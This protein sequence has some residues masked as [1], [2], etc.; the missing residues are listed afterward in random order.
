MDTG[1]R[2]NDQNKVISDFFYIKL[3]QIKLFATGESIGL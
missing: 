2:F 1:K 3:E